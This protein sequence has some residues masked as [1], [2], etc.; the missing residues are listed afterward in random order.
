M[1]QK[2]KETLNLDKVKF[3]ELIDYCLAC[4]GMSRGDLADQLGYKNKQHV[5]NILAKNTKPISLE[6]LAKW[7]KVLE[8]PMSDLVNGYQYVDPK[9]MAAIDRRLKKVETALGLQESDAEKLIE[10]H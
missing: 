4:R 10:I 2:A 8:Y 5:N 9:S 3:R 1:A 7:C 6:V